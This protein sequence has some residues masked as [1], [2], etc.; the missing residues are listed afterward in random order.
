MKI[1]DLQFVKEIDL[2]KKIERQTLIMN[3]GRRENSAEHS[4]HLAMSVYT[5]LEYCPNPLNLEKCLLLALIHDIVEIDA[6]DT[7]VYNNLSNKQA[8]E[9]KTLDRLIQMLPS[10]KAEEVK[11]LWFEYEDC[12]TY[13]SQY[14]NALD[15]FLPIL[16]NYFNDGYSWRNHKIK[17][18][19]VIERNKIKIINGLPAL[20]PIV[21][22]IMESGIDSGYLIDE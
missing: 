20:W 18:S 14:V 22:H 19:Q 10:K 5:Y 13:E 2:L 1:D 16:A 11:S 9:E 8:E 17:K 21:E 7:F 4:W 12:K 6:G 15:R 3:G